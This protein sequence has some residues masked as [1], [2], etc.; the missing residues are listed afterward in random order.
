MTPG[1]CPALRTLNLRGESF[2]PFTCKHSYVGNYIGAEGALALARLLA[3]LGACPALTELNL[4]GEISPRT[5][6]L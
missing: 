2:L 1:A 3:T 6:T 4:E 5:P